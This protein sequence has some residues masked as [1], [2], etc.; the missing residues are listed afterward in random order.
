MDAP[1]FAVAPFATPKVSTP[2]HT[3]DHRASR[4]SQHF[5]AT[6]ELSSRRVVPSAGTCATAASALL[7]ALN[8]GRPRRRIVARKDAS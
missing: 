5:R 3:K 1:A 6:P 8:K 2:L 4:L 7:L